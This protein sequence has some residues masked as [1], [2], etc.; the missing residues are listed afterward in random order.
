V[1]NKNVITGF[2]IG[3]ENT[4]LKDIV[5]F[6]YLHAYPMYRYI[7]ILSGIYDAIAVYIHFFGLIRTT[8]NEIFQRLY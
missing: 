6:S 5:Y 3:V 7:N 2:K 8:I 4:D 1:S